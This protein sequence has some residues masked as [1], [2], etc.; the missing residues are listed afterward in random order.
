MEMVDEG[1]GEAVSVE[2]AEVASTRPEAG[3]AGRQCEGL[4]RVRIV[5]SGQGQ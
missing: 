4:A 3:A 5:A 1:H 2:G